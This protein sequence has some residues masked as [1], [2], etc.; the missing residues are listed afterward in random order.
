MFKIK[1][2]KNNDKLKSLISTSFLVGN[3]P[4]S[5]IILLVVP[6]SKRASFTLRVYFT[7]N[8]FVLQGFG[9]CVVVACL[10]KIENLSPIASATSCV[11][12]LSR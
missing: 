3:Q 8:F 1:Y 11:K 9:V 12:N 7:L 6:S 5:L 4:E 2:I 10:R